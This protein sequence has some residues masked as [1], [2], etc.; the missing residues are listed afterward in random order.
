MSEFES[1]VG[2][3]TKPVTA[4]PFLFIHFEALEAPELLSYLT[5]SLVLFLYALS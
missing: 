5:I 1:G 3:L 2:I 4:C